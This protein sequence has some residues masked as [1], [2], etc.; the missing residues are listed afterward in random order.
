MEICD[1]YSSASRVTDLESAHPRL[2]EPPAARFVKLFR[3]TK[4]REDAIDV[5]EGS[6]WTPDRGVAEAYT[7]N[8]GWGGPHVVSI[9]TS[10]PAIDVRG[11][12]QRG[13]HWWD[14]APLARILNED[15]DE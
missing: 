8:P 12:D 4:R 11:H 9:E 2:D 5:P 15:A 1:A 6:C 14:L 7:E 3:A 10:E 13:T